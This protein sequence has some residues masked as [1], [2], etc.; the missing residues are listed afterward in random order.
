MFGFKSSSKSKRKSNKSPT[1]PINTSNETKH[2]HYVPSVSQIAPLPQNKS[3]GILPVLSLDG[4]DAPSS[5]PSEASE[6]D[7]PS[8]A[9]TSNSASGRQPVGV[10]IK[11]S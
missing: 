4:R 2:F 10:Y 11:I 3:H 5:M 9:A 7:L 1:T 8:N 6:N